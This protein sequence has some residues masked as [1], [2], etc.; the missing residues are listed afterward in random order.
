MCY[1]LWT[2]IFVVIT[3]CLKHRNRLLHTKKKSQYLSRCLHHISTKTAFFKNQI[4]QRFAFNNLIITDL[5]NVV[6]LSVNRKK[7]VTNLP[8]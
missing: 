2:S 4:N 6:K 7:Y 3:G 8:S 1:L 5:P